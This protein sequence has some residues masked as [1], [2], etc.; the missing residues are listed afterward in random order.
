MIE[1]TEPSSRLVMI[2]LAVVL[3]AAGVYLVGTALRQDRQAHTTPEGFTSVA[4]G[5]A[6]VPTSGERGSATPRYRALRETAVRLPAAHPVSARTLATFYER[7]AYPGA[8]PQIPHAVKPD[9]AETGNSCLQCHAEGD[10]AP[11]FGAYAP[12]SPHPELLSCRQCHVPQQVEEVFAETAWSTVRPPSLG[13]AA[14]PG[15]PPPIPHS[16][17]M[18]ENCLSCH[19]GPAA[20]HEIRS[21]HPERLQCLQCHVPAPGLS[22]R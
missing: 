6:P 7:R 8:S 22:P 10:Y 9:M 19:S 11:R 17:Q 20:I 18:R 4:R 5:G 15:G 14:I 3:M 12:V 16:L 21:G 1:N 13:R 2:G